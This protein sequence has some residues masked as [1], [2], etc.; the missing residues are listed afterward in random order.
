MNNNVKR[1]RPPKK[2]EHKRSK[3]FLLKMRELEFETINTLY[4]QAQKEHNIE[5][6]TDFI[7]KSATGKINVDLL[8]EGIK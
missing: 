3:A 4:L 6:L 1:G 8:R 5:S 7:I 2:M